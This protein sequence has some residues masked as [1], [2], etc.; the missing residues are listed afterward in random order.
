MAAA[1]SAPSCVREAAGSK[2]K[3]IGNSLTYIC[4]KWKM[5]ATLA[6]TRCSWICQYCLWHGA[7][8]AREDS[9]IH[10]EPLRKTVMC[11]PSLP[12]GKAIP[13]LFPCS[14]PRHCFSWGANYQWHFLE[15]KLGV[16]SE[17]LCSCCLFW[18]QRD[19]SSQ[20]QRS[21]PRCYQ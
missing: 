10:Q 5:W 2:G 4:L 17:L 3:I 18:L 9:C 6:Q 14:S 20:P 8:Q 1:A 12:S 21:L 13:P 11:W 15:K 19:Y 7:G 16:L